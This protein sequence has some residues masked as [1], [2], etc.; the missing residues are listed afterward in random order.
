MH[1]TKILSLA[2]K[3]LNAIIE[4][5]SD[6]EAHLRLRL[7]LVAL[8]GESAAKPP[9]A[10]ATAATTLVTPVDP[11]G[12][13]GPESVTF[14]ATVTPEGGI[15][16]PADEDDEPEDDEQEDDEPIIPDGFDDRA[17]YDNFVLSQAEAI[18]ADPDRP[19]EA[20]MD[21]VLGVVGTDD[22]GNDLGDADALVAQAN[23]FVEQAQEAE[24][25]EAEDGY[26]AEQLNPAETFRIDY[27][28]GDEQELTA[29]Q[30]Q[31]ILDSEASRNLRLMGTMIV[32]RVED[33]EVA[34]N[35]TAVLR[36]EGEGLDLEAIQRGFVAY[37]GQKVLPGIGRIVAIGRAA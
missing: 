15:F 7:A 20:Y 23:G 34:C 2:R 35:K 29:A 36:F 37:R 14:A 12:I 31:Q 17:A 30:V 25:Q 6:A 19:A 21:G 32:V 28:R 10:G 24:Q 26:E 1:T 16:D 4:L 9:S 13:N 5:T 27:S 8:E 22:D 3:Q 18:A 33:G 11:D